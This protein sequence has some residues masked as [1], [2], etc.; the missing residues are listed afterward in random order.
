MMSEHPDCLSPLCDCMDGCAVKAVADAARAAA[1]DEAAKVAEG[2]RSLAGE[3]I[4]A[5][6]RELKDR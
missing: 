5:S 2:Y 3:K 4:A 1:L 6:I